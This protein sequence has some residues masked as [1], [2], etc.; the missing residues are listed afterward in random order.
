[1]PSVRPIEVQVTVV[2]LDLVMQ[3]QIE[4][5]RKLFEVQ[6]LRS[7]DI[8]QRSARFCYFHWPKKKTLEKFW[9]GCNDKCMV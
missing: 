9:K 1:M 6:T 7:L 8:Y 2:L 3:R 4:V 5:P